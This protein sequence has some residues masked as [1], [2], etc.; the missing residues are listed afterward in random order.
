MNECLLSTNQR[1]ISKGFQVMTWLKWV[2]YTHNNEAKLEP[3][4]IL[5]I[6]ST[7]HF[8]LSLWLWA[9]CWCLNKFYFSIAVFMNWIYLLY[10]YM[11]LE[12]ICYE[13]VLSL[14]L[15]FF[16]FLTLTLILQFLNLSHDLEIKSKSYQNIHRPIKHNQK[17][18]DL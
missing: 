8:L 11:K 13:E 12:N 15:L 16:Y 2:L 10:F 6:R 14:F 18:P 4:K 9:C 17:L 7:R 5:F 1:S 3:Q